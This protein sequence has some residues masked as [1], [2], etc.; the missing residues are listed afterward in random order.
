MIVNFCR[1]RLHWLHLGRIM[2]CHQLCAY[3]LG[4]RRGGNLR[5]QGSMFILEISLFAGVSSNILLSIS[6]CLCFVHVGLCG[7]VLWVSRFLGVFLRGV[8]GKV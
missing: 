3:G 1:V 6:C 7:L 5:E 4:F 2:F 8:C